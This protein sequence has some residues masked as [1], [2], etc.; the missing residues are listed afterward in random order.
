MR[1]S[2]LVALCCPHPLDQFLLVELAVEIL[3]KD[4][5]SIV[6]KEID[7]SKKPPYSEQ[8]SS[9]LLHILNRNDREARRPVPLIGVYD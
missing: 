8:P 5:L 3:W 2:N 9:I 4:F 7:D 6:Y 1:R